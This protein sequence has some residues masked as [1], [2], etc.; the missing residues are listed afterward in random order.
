MH[1]TLPSSRAQ[2]TGVDSS[3]AALELSRRNAE[4]NGVEGVCSFTKGDAAD[5]MKQV[6]IQGLQSYGNAGLWGSGG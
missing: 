4:L 3:A 6:G 5:Y 2:V 1:H